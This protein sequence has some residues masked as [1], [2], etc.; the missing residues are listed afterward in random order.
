MSFTR[1][2]PLPC[3]CIPACGSICWKCTHIRTL[4]EMKRAAEMMAVWHLRAS[5]DEH[6]ILRHGTPLLPI[7]A[8]PTAT[9]RKEELQ[10]CRDSLHQSRNLADRRNHGLLHDIGGLLDPIDS[11]S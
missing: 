2:K 3:Y 1:A 8:I 5:S 4:E 9:A 11:A 6:L 10:A 7:A